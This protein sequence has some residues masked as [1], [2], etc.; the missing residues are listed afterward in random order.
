VRIAKPYAITNTNGD[1]H[2]SGMFSHAM[3]FVAKSRGRQRTRNL[4]DMRLSKVP[5]T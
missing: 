1:E 3:A 2:G 5:N 4:D